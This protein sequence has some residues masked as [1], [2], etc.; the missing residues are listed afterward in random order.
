M[1]GGE[2]N[3]PVLPTIQID[4][5]GRGDAVIPPNAR[6][7]ANFHQGGKRTRAES[8]RRPFFER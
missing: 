3:I 8:T 2:R 7:A 1:S 5:V 4:S 6:W